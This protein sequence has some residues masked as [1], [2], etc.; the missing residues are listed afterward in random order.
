[1]IENPKDALRHFWTIIYN[2][3]QLLNEGNI[4]EAKRECEGVRHAILTDL[5]AEGEIFK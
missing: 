3:E 2:I 4:E 5:K 1:M